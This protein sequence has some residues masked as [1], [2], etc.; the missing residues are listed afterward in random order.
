MKRILLNMAAL[1]ALAVGAAAPAQYPD[2]N[3][4]NDNR[5]YQNQTRAY[6]NSSIAA[7][8]EQLQTRIQVGVQSG[9]ISRQEARPLR[10]QLRQL[11]QLEYQ[12]SRNGLTGRE[13]AELQQRMRDLRRQVR[14]ADGGGRGRYDRY[15]RDD[16]GRSDEQYDRVDRNNDGWDDRDYDRDGR[17]DDDANNRPY[18]QPLQRGDVG[19]LIDGVLGT[20]GLRVGQQA[21]S[22]LSGVPYEYRD[23]YRD[24]NGVYY[25]SDGRSIY[26]IN[27]RTQTVVGVYPM[28]R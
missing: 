22:D 4:P 24:G 13:R 10:Q 28:D 15:D 23:Q 19:G 14:L 12:Y 25:R 26:Q 6:A 2:D 5:G 11:K 18:Q 16:Y 20:G 8:I 9:D 3:Y 21:S 7:R 1:S 27:A 17:W